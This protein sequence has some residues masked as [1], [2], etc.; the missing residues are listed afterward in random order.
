MN[1]IGSTYKDVCQWASNLGE[2]F[3]NKTAFL[4]PTKFHTFLRSL[5]MRGK[6]ASLITMNIDQLEQKAGLENVLYIHGRLDQLRCVNCYKT[7]AFSMKDLRFYQKRYRVYC[8]CIQN[9]RSRARGFFIPS[10]FLYNDPRPNI[11]ANTAIEMS[12]FIETD[13]IWIVGS[14][15][16]SNV[17]G[18]HSMIKDFLK[19]EIPIYFI[20]IA[21]PPTR[22]LKKFQYICKTAD[23]FA[24]EYSLKELPSELPRKE[25]DKIKAFIKTFRFKSFTKS[26]IARK[27]PQIRGFLDQS[28]QLLLEQEFLQRKGHIH[29]AESKSKQL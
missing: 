26:R 20:N 19:R 23:Q 3:F 12:S 14:S 28:L 21:C 5:Q 15:L 10:V 8:S 16:P 22:Y 6:I 1:S 11:D 7:R 13:C 24:E 27:F 29:F 25:L 18:I 17:Q 9:K 4:K 2:Y